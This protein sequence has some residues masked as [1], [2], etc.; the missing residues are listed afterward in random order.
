MEVLWDGDGVPP[1]PHVNRQ[2]P[3]KTVPSRRTTF[4]G[5]N[6]NFSLRYVDN[7]N[8]RDFGKTLMSSDRSK[9][10]SGLTLASGND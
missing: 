8:I 5:G 9:V 6:D 10:Y 3:V 7:F 2:T 1:S 4:V